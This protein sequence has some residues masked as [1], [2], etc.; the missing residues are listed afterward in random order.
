MSTMASVN[1]LSFT[2]ALFFI[3]LA[4]LLVCLFQIARIIW[5]KAIAGL[6]AE[7]ARERA[8]DDKF[9]PSDTTYCLGSLAF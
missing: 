6:I 3:Y 4:L 8:P 2:F 5:N 1:P 9:Y 7:Y